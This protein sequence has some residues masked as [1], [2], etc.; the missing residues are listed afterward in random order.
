MQSLKHQ[1]DIRLHPSRKRKLPQCVLLSTMRTGIQQ[2]GSVPSVVMQCF[3][4]T[5]SHRITTRIHHIRTN[6]LSPVHTERFACTTQIERR[7]WT[8][9]CGLQLN[10]PATTPLTLVALGA[11]P[12][13]VLIGNRQH[14]HHLA[15][16]S[17][18]P[19]T[20]LQPLATHKRLGHSLRCK[21]E[22]QQIHNHPRLTPLVRPPKSALTAKTGRPAVVPELPRPFRGAVPRGLPVGGCALTA[23][24]F[25]PPATDC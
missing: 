24:R 9:M 4:I 6:P 7:G 5:P 16:T 25:Q 23:R 12:T 17:R 8:Q 15:L 19:I 22:F 11:Q 20:L 10:T 13:A 14:P 2:Y 3:Q 21:E 1:Q 18:T